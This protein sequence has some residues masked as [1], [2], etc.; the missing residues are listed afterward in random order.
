M[1]EANPLTFRHHASYIQDSRTASLQATLF[2]YL[3]NNIFND[4]F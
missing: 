3:I 1:A 2:V 4:F